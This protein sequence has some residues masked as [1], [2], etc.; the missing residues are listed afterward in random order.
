M[1]NSNV[2]TFRSTKKLKKKGGQIVIKKL[3]QQSLI[4]PNKIKKQTTNKQQTNNKNKI[5]K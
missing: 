2:Q 5:N 3:K 4:Y 1:K